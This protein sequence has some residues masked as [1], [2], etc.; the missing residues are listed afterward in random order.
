MILEF[1]SF[2]LILEYGIRN[3]ESEIRLNQIVNKLL[4]GKK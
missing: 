3:A 1:A 2:I 4:K